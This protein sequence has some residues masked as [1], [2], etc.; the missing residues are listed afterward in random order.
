[1]CLPS[2]ASMSQPRAAFLSVCPGRCTLTAVWG[3]TSSRKLICTDTC[4]L[5]PL[6]ATCLLCEYSAHS[7][8]KTSFRSSQHKAA[9]THRISGSFPEPRLTCS[10]RPAAAS[11]L[12]T[13]LG[14]L[15]PRPIWPLRDHRPVLCQFIQKEALFKRN[16][17][18][19]FFKTNV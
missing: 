13:S 17:F 8:S 3:F 5:Q 15:R 6:S 4:P 7:L 1:M 11:S 19:F 16:F 18:F 12:D 9:G 14:C 2:G 10:H